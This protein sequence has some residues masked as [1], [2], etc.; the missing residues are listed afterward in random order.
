MFAV[1]VILED[2]MQDRSYAYI[3]DSS[4]CE[5]MHDS[6]FAYISICMLERSIQIC[7]YAHQKFSRICNSKQFLHIYWKYR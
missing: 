5:Y 3:H 4:E 6:D 1:L 7:L 2:M